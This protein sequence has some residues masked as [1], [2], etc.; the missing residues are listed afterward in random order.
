MK[1][2]LLV[3]GVVISAV[4]ARAQDAGVEEVEI[5]DVDDVTQGYTP[6]EEQ[7]HETL[8]LTGYI[9][10]GFV[11]ATGD[12]T[13][14]VPDDTR[15]PLDYGVDPFATAVNSRGDVA[16]TSSG[17]RWTNGFRPRSVGIGG[18][19]SFLINT[20]SADVRF[21]PRGLPIFAFA[22]VQLMPRLLPT[23]DQTR[24]ELQQAFGR[25]SPFSSQEF[26]L[27]LGKFD[28]VFGIEYL[29]N[30]ANLRTGITPSLIAR[31]TTGHSLGAKA[32]YRVQLPSAMSALSV[33]AALTN[34]GTRIEA[35]VPPDGS[36]VGVPV[37]S[38][39]A[40]Y[41]LNLQHVQAKVGVSGLYG[42]R[43]DQ[44]S[45]GARQLALGVDA[46]LNWSGLSVAGELLRLVD[47]PGPLAGKVTGQGPAELASG[48][49]VWGGWA[50]VAYTLP[51]KNE[52]L[53]GLT[54]YG[55][56]DRRHAAFEGYTEVRTQRF[57]VGARIDL[58]EL[59]ALKAEGVL[60]A[61]LGGAPAVDNDVFTASAVFTW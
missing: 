16:S 9:D 34:N 29:E 1:A 26:A 18:N 42:P 31:Y 45:P 20:A 30:E 61:E 55:R 56:Y 23:G 40:G 49:Q 50:R 8:R 43:N 59:L 12:G 17:E 24:I 21:Q 48:F 38:G 47:E 36:V 32:F 2:R 14:Y 44:R 11:K 41:E 46:R 15:A 6:S 7:A 22:R 54:L 53:T 39:R 3:L 37:L 52:V 13:S 25:V 4:G 19:P 58:F 27:F 10:V 28:S 35:L 33:N 5:V 60:N 57:T 51:W